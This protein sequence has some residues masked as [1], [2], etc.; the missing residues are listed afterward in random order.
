MFKGQVA[1]TAQEAQAQAFD[2]A[3][4]TAGTSGE[5]HTY[6]GAPH[7]FANPTNGT[8]FRAEAA[9]DAWTKTLAFLKAKL[10]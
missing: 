9:A 2:T 1:K 5:I 3:L 10:Q 8:A 6:A 7:A 4:T